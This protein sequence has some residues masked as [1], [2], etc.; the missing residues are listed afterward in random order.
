VTERILAPALFVG[1]GLALALPAKAQDGRILRVLTINIQEDAKDGRLPGVT[2]L[3]RASSADVVNIQ[4]VDKNG[5]TIA[6][7]LGFHFLKEGPDTAVLSRFEIA[8]PT[9]GKHGA[10]IVFPGGGKIAVFNVHFLYK[11]YQPYQLLGIPY[12]D[13][14]FFKTEAEAVAAAIKTRG[15]EVA[16]ALKDIAGLAD[17]NMAV[18]LTGDFN[19]PSHQDW[20]EAAAKARRHPIKVVWPA[21]KAFV[22]A[23]LV[24]VYR[25]LYPDEIARPGNTWTPTT[26]AADPKDHHDRIDFIFRRGAGLRT[27]TVDVVGEKSPESTVVFEPYPTDHRAVLASFALSA[28]DKKPAR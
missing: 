23:G 25:E 9:A 24:D 1:L 27:A 4:E 11:P 15:G 17:K 5:E 19:E 3:I 26:A 12:G 10:V 14:P 7:A 16:D 20:T 6:A 13:D 8:G 28:S 22:D 2:E 18:V 21:T